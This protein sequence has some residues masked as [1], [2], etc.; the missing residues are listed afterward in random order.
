MT[1]GV[2]ESGRVLWT[3]VGHLMRRKDQRIPK[4]NTRKDIRFPI[5]YYCSKVFK[6]LHL[7]VSDYLDRYYNFLSI[8]S[9]FAS[10]FGFLQNPGF[11]CIHL[12]WEIGGSSLT[13][14]PQSPCYRNGYLVRQELEKESSQA[15]CA[16]HIT[17]R[18]SHHGHSEGQNVR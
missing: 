5:C 1:Q 7:L 8:F 9:S 6:F 13:E 14:V 18:V 15:W 10:L 3:Y 16:D 4:Q 12:S 2:M 11:G 17:L